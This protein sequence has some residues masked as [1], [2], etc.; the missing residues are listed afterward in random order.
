MYSWL[1]PASIPVNV[2]ESGLSCA[3][4]SPSGVTICVNEISNLNSF[5][6]SVAGTP[7]TVFLMVRPTC[8]VAFANVAVVTGA[9]LVLPD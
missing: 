9:N 3:T 1:T 8:L 6:L 2:P 7:S 4:V 5:D